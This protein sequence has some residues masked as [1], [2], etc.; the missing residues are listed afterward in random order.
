MLPKG[1]AELWRYWLDKPVGGAG[2]A[3]VDVTVAEISGASASSFALQFLARA[4]NLR[5]QAGCADETCF[6]FTGGSR[7]VDHALEN[8]HNIQI[9]L[10][11][12]LQ[13]TLAVDVFG[14]VLAPSFLRVNYSI[15]SFGNREIRPERLPLRTSKNTSKTS[16]CTGRFREL[17]LMFSNAPPKFS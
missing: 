16:G 14:L 15:P 13:E 9:R 11:A 6:S 4:S 1:S 3:S 10:L 5:S 2:V 17:L 8:S 12:P 7:S